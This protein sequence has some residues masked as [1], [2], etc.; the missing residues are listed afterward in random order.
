MNVKQW[1]ACSILKA[2]RFSKMYTY[3]SIPNNVKKGCKGFAL[4]MG[5][6][7]KWCFNPSRP[8]PG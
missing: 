3:Y 6:V 8:D 1:T 7:D 5:N 2:S 4:V